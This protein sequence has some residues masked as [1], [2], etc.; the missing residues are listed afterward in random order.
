MTNNLFRT[1]QG[2]SA[3]VKNIFCI[4]RNYLEHAQELKNEVPTEPVVFIKPTSSLALDQEPIVI[5][6]L[7]KNVHHELELVIAIDAW[8]IAKGMDTF[9]ALSPFLK[10]DS[11]ETRD[12]STLEL[13]LFINGELKQK[14]KT[15]QMIFDIGT[16]IS[17]LSH[18]FT[19]EAG[20][21][22]YTGT[23]AGVG[24]LVSGDTLESNL[25]A[26]DKKINWKTSV[27]AE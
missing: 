6:A 12:W 20:D 8:T 18:R 3:P 2:M 25:F 16:I 27:L 14:G 23:P 7:S 9:A 10:I 17:F 24:K 21:I 13:E 22:I 26:F 5:P 1:P 15:S 4:G 11:P 19:L